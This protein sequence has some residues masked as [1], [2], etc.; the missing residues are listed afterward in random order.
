MS[1]TVPL[2]VALLTNFVQPY[3]L[4]FFQAI[5]RKVSA[6]TVFI[7]TPMEANRPWQPDHE[8][9]NV[10]QQKS[11]THTGGWRHPRGF[12]EDV[13][14]HVPYD[15][16]WQL[17]RWRP[18]V[19]I[20]GQMGFQ[21]TL[22]LIYRRLV[23]A[24]RL[25]LWATISDQSEQGRGRLRGWLRRLIVPRA[26]A[27]LV[28]GEAGARYIRR[29]GVPEQK[30][31]HVPYITQNEPFLALPLSRSGPAAR[32]LLFSGQLIGRKGIDLF[33]DALNAW[34]LAHPHQ[35]VEFWLLGDGPLKSRLAETK[36]PENLHLRFMA[37]IPYRDL[38][39]VYA[40]AGILA[41]PTLADEWGMVINEAMASGLPVLASAYSQAV[42][43]LVT[44]G[45]TGWIFHPDR[46]DE[47]YNALDR[48]LTASLEQLDAMRAQAR[49]RLEPL[50]PAFAAERVLDA[51]RF[52]SMDAFGQRPSR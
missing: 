39:A 3:R 26:D 24:C 52:V 13:Y 21:T 34:A 33:M 16:L 42:E 38:P 23:P 47:M 7:A 2:R 15:T 12:A 40:Q 8:G 17:W 49:A 37:N 44:E 27:V 41:F 11:F 31:F 4:P 51:L 45:E 18:E 10:I 25:I 28:N 29:F 22:A 50:N 35:E 48:A 6:L 20:S 19:I 9:L 14:V 43:E 1:E 30:I 32:R 46:P 5:A 36:R